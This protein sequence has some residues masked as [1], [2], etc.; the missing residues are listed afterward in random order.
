MLGLKPR[1]PAWCSFHYSSLSPENSQGAQWV[2]RGC[3]WEVR[4]RGREEWGEEEEGE[5]RGS[6][7]SGKN[8][9]TPAKGDV[10]KF[11]DK[12]K[13]GGEM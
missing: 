11:R 12:R 6:G 8:L 10:Y 1:T 3:P 2:K 5:K 7:G 9:R 13:A 4:K